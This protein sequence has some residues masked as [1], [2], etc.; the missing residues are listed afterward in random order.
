MTGAQK[1]DNAKVSGAKMLVTKSKYTSYFRERNRMYP[2]NCQN[3]MEGT[4]REG[5]AGEF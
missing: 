5:K 1:L 3:A 4:F 2:V